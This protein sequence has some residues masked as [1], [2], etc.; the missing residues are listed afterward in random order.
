MPWRTRH[1][2]PYRFHVARSHPK[3]AGLRQSEWLTGVVDADD[4]PAD[5]R[6]LLSDPRDTILVVH[7]W[8][9]REGQYV[10]TFR[11]EAA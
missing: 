7:V 5:A 11:K 10:M 9:Q 2:G 8:S 6:A 4:V 3:K 1:R